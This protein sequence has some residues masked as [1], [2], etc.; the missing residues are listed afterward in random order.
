M[1]AGRWA[2]VGSLFAIL[3]VGA[4]ATSI[5]VVLPLS[6]LQGLQADTAAAVVTWT[7][8]LLVSYA[9]AALVATAQAVIF[10]RLTNWREGVP[11]A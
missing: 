7:I 2:I 10:R 3:F 1:P 5:A 4:V 6:L 9:G 11:L 8:A